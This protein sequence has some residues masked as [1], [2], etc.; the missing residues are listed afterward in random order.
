MKSERGNLVLPSWS[1]SDGLV[2]PP[3]VVSRAVG[4]ESVLLNLKTTVYF[5]ADSVA[6]QMWVTL[7]Q[8]DTIQAAFESLLAVYEVTPKVLRHDLEEFI[9]QL[10]DH[11]L[12]EIKRSDTTV[13]KVV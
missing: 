5:G 8:S 6:S 3:D 2:V 4:E 9:Q 1:F 11:G 7:T 10:L 12:I 13:E